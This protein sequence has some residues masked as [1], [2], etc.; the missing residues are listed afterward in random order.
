MIRFSYLDSSNLDVE[1]DLDVE[2]EQEFINEIKE[3]I[4]QQLKI[5]RKSISKGIAAELINEK[6][7]TKNIKPKK[8]AKIDETEIARAGETF[9]INNQSIIH[10]VEFEY[11]KELNY[12]QA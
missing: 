9:L 10:C 6:A 2:S 5:M 12:S 4:E 1:S 7:V 11:S 8:L 3:S